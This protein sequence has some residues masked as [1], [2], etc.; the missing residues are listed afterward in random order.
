[1]DAALDPLFT[2][3]HE[4]T[5]DIRIGG[6]LG[7]S[8]HTK[9]EFKILRDIRQAKRKIRKLNLRKAKFQL[10]RELV[11][12]TVWDSVLEPREQSIVV[13]SCLNYYG[14]L[15]ASVDK[16]RAMDVICLD[17]N[18]A[19]N[20]VPCNHFLQIRKIWIWWIRNWL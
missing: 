14:G 16:Q 20:T 6:C 5:D 19:F 18:E 17:F 15:I 12:K 10:F 11:N 8:D 3:A 9:V 13:K 2:N 7:C 4:L 1:M